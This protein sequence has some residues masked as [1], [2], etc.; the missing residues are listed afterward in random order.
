MAGRRKFKNPRL[1][2]GVGI[3]DS[4]YVT[5]CSSTRK[6]CPY[7]L[8]WKNML[9]RAYCKIERLNRPSYHGTSICDEWLR[10][11]NFKVWMD[12]QDRSG[13]QL[14]KDLLFAGNKIYSPETCCFVSREINTFLT[15]SAATRGNLLIGVCIHKNTGKFMAQIRAQS[16]GREYIGIFDSEL[17]A[18]E[19]WRKRKHEIALQLA[20]QQTDPR[21][22]KALSTRYLK[23][24]EQHDFT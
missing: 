13:K 22:A 23:E 4:D 6:I 20:A 7:F 24:G 19:A 5:Q 16:K 12:S 10:F 1:T 9:K 8:A 21:T 11:S 15:D 18:H 3:N 14:D 2:Y 17:D